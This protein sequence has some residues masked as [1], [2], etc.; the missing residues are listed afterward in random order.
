MT[1]T[2]LPPAT[3]RF[4]WLPQLRSRWWTVVLGASLMLNLLVVGNVA[5]SFVRGAPYERMMGASYVQLVPRG[6]FRQLPAERRKELM[7]IVRDNRDDLRALR[8]QFEGTSVKLADAL[9]KD[10][11]S[12]DEVRAT[13]TA[14][15]TGTESLAARGGDVVVKIVTALT[16][17]ERK[18]L[19]SSIRQREARSKRKKN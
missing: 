8:Q 1:D 12:M 6:F 13:V 19:A 9:E 18:L 15:S 17:E 16:P 11:F 10:A 3:P 14:F 7:Q 4:S 2:S 5:G